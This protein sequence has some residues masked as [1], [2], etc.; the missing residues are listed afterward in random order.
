MR[1]IIIVLT[2]IGLSFS[3][4]MLIYGHVYSSID[5]I[6]AIIPVPNAQVFIGMN[7]VPE[8]T[9]TFTDEDSSSAFD[10]DARALSYEDARGSYNL[11]SG[12]TEIFSYS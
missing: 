5:P 8:G 1:K 4:E 12:I 9:L 6:G 7:S 11:I 3:Q 10:K 2:F